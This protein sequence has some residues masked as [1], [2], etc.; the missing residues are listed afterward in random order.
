MK[1]INLLPDW[2]KQKRRLKI[3]R[4]SQYAALIVM[5]ALLC[6]WNMVIVNACDKLTDHVLEIE[7]KLQPQHKSMQNL[8]K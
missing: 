2:Y 1:D 5:M 8:T 7:K 3:S 6:I 4:R